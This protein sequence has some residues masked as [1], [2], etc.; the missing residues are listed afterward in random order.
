M[1]IYALLFPLKMLFIE[2]LKT[3]FALPKGSPTITICGRFF[4]EFREKHTAI[5][6]IY[7]LLNAE[8]NLYALK[9]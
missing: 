7:S 3:L 8:V 5:T 1:S 9:N 6:A 2:V 4:V